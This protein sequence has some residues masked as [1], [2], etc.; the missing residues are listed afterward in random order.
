M[1]E[2][3]I[4]VTKPSGAEEELLLMRTFAQVVSKSPVFFLLNPNVYFCVY[5]SPSLAPTFSL[6]NPITHPHT[7]FLQD[8]FYYYYYYST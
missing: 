8:N 4:K 1:N 6:M 2:D 5:R 3:L 7:T